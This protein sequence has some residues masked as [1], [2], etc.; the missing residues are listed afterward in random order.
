MDLKPQNKQLT[1]TIPSLK[2]SS[3]S[4]NHIL[5]LALIIASF[6]LGSLIT[7]VKY[8]EYNGTGSKTASA[9]SAI[10]QAAAQQPQ[11]PTA[12]SKVQV[13]AGNLPLKGNSNAKVTIVEFADFRCPFCEKFFTDIEPQLIKDYVDTG[14]AKLA[15]RNFAFLGPASVVAANAGECAN[16]QAKFWDMHDYL[17]KNQ[18]SE[19]DTSMYTTDKLTTIAG[20]L[21]MDT[22][23]FKSCLDGNKY[24]KN[25]SDDLAAGQK[26]G[27][28]GTP[29]TFVNGTPVIGA[30]PY[31]Q[32]KTAID[33]ELQK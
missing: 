22:A 21:G 24:D 33:A 26:A 9:P 6:L 30:V 10:K 31:N 23:K 3:L 19:S 17:Y 5:V 16:E 20:Q 7:K 1:I 27:V 25:V 8:L 32:L 28:S 12:P 29:T 18:P 15:F 11:A 13:D 4:A 14:K 2:F